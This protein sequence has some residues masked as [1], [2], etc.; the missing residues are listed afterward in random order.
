MPT[1]RQTV[2]V[3]T[4]TTKMMVFP[5]D[6]VAN[7]NSSTDK[8]TTANDAQTRQITCFLLFLLRAVRRVLFFSISVSLAAIY[9]LK[10]LSVSAPQNGHFLSLLLITLLQYTHV[11]LA[12]IFSP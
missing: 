9:F 10:E 11:S 6:G 8:I 7:I 5:V 3:K 2:Y 4:N 1:T 12:I